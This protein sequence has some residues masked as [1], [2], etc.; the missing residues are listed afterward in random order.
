MSDVWTESW[1]ISLTHY[2]GKESVTSTWAG[3][4]ITKEMYDKFYAMLPPPDM[5]SVMSMEDGKKANKFLRTQ[6]QNTIIMEA[7]DD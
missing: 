1:A 5:T 7:D 4:G 6:L 2:E 3:P